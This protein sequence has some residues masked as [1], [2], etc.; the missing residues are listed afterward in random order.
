MML[1]CGAL[2]GGE[3]KVYLDKKSD[4]LD[5]YVKNKS[6]APITIDFDLEVQDLTSDTEQHQ[7]VVEANSE[8]KLFSL[9]GTDASGR[10]NCHSD[11][12]YRIG[13]A[14][15]EHD[16]SYLYRIPFEKGKAVEVTQGFEGG[17]SHSGELCYAVDW[18]V[19]EG[20]PVYAARGGVVIR[21][22]E[23]YRKGGREKK[24]LDKANHLFVLHSD[25]TIGAY[26]HFKHRG[27]AV[28]KGDQ[29]KEG[30][31]IGYS[32]N[33]GLS[34]G[35][36]LHFDVRAPESGKK[37]RTFPVFFKTEKDPQEILKRGRFY[38]AY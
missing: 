33:T 36:H 20:T 37:I 26:L 11:Y 19:P 10:W 38:A 35:P 17:Y 6:L 31:L 34:T 8:K 18:A 25:G 21:K 14:D 22:Q 1:L 15:C 4:L 30:T 23:K 24:Y 16:D 3:V 12:S 7:F 13:S 27:V 32:G 9:S 28:K 29:I 5:F 2:Q